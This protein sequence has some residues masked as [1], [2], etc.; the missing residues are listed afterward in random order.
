MPQCLKLPPK[1][2]HLLH[3]KN[4]KKIKY[5]LRLMPDQEQTIIFSTTNGSMPPITIY[6]LNI[7]SI[8][9]GYKPPI[10][11]YLAIILSSTNGS[12][13][14]VSMILCR[15]LQYTSSIKYSIKK[16]KAC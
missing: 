11:I 7:I 5:H 13:P 9:N 6:L 15:Q 12:T 14:P 8:P 10:K 3:Q 1:E 4:I 2:T 16:T